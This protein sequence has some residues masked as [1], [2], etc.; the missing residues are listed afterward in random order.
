[1]L[2]TVLC[3]AFFYRLVFGVGMAQMTVE[4]NT[5][6]DFGRTPPGKAVCSAEEGRALSADSYI[7]FF[8]T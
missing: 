4:R 2:R 8:S 7:A 6:V 5:A 3:G 1:M